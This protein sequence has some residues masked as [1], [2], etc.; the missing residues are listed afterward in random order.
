MANTQSFTGDDPWRRYVSLLLRTLAGVLAFLFLFLV[1]V[2]PYGNLPNTIFRHHAIMD[3]NQRWQYPAIV[4]SQEFDSLVIGTST[5]RLM[6]P[7]ILNEGFGGKFANLAMNSARAWEQYRIAKLFFDEVPDA[8]TLLVGLDHVWC[9]P[10]AD[11]VRITER[12]FPEWMYDRNP[13]NDLLYLLNSKSVEISGRRIG[14]GL[15]LKRPRIPFDGYEVFV[16]PEAEYDAARAKTHIG[17]GRAAID[18]P[19]RASAEVRASWRFP[20][21]AWLDELL[22][23]E[24]PKVVL[25]I[26]P[27][28]VNVQPVPGSIE[29][30]R[31]ATCKREMAEVA[32]RHG[33][34][35]FDF[36]IP[37]AIT[38]PDENFWD[39]LHSRVPVA[40]NVVHRLIRAAGNPQIPGDGT[41]VTLPAV[42]RD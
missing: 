34:V 39:P 1:L 25:V 36:R 42:S 14:E 3:I 10:E 41:Y 4:R 13:W 17:E 29:A 40:D 9:D 11:K 6:Q 28:H 19:E 23:L 38:K 12:G 5:S 26:T 15:G 20:A 27:V 8:R 30:E 35:V 21:L 16:P 37:S 2:N 18:P 7:S 22:S 32:Q 31:E 33:L 24:W